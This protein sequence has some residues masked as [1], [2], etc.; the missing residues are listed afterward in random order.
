[1]SS[2][3]WIS[4]IVK[5]GCIIVIPRKGLQCS[6][7]DTFG[8]IVHK[9]QLTSTVEKVSNSNNAMFVDSNHDV[10]LNAPLSLCD[11]FKCM[12]VC[13]NVSLSDNSCSASTSTST[14]SAPVRNGLEMLMAANDAIILP[15]AIVP[16]EDG[17][18]IRKDQQLY[19]DLLSMC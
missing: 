7:E 4:V 16:S 8:D 11:Q 15:P 6:F 19:N 1:M 2:F 5:C 14:S 3:L 12:L 10:P 9:L 18:E 13:I 17:K